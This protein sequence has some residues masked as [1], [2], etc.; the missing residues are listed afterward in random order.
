MS[1]IGIQNLVKKIEYMF[2]K[3]HAVAYVHMALRVAHYKVNHPLEYYSAFLSSRVNSFEP[4]AMLEGSDS[5]IE[6][7][8]ELCKKGPEGS[9]VTDIKIKEEKF[10]N[11][12]RHFEVIY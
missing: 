8:I 5:L 12:F 2:P 11:K 4:E 1:Q 3:A 7:L 9:E 6:K 10:K